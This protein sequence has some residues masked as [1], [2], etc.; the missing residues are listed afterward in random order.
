MNQ[1]RIGP[2][3]NPSQVTAGPDLGVTPG[4]NGIGGTD[5]FGEIR[6]RFNLSL[7]SPTVRH[8]LDPNQVTAEVGIEIS[9]HFCLLA[10][11]SS[12]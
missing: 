6:L 7:I 9:S 2:I 1:T 11:L 4:L 3:L 8:V 10:S 12:K 5:S